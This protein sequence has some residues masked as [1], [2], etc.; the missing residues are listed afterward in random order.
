MHHHR[1]KSSERFLNKEIILTELE[2][3]PGQTILDAGCGNGYMSK[4]FSRIL[5][6]T[7]QVYALDPDAQAIET[8]AQEVGGTNIKPL[9][10]DISQVT[11]LPEASIDLIYLATVLH[12]F[13]QTEIDGFKKE[14]KRLL[15]PQGRL[16]IVEINK[17]PTLFGP[18]LNMRFSPQELI[19]L[20]SLIPEQTVA[21]GEFFYMQTFKN[22]K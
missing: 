13:S 20:M 18:P 10:G 17:E 4:E 9:V 5:N 21:V 14:V 3:N 11:E 1:G 6:N 8:L 12:G 15:K 19:N 7:G 2:I 16:A 22:Q